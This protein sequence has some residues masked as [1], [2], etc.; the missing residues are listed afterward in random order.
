MRT[1][2]AL[3]G[4]L[5]RVVF[6]PLWLLAWRAR[7]PR[8]AWIELRLAAELGEIAMPQPPWRAFLARWQPRRLRSIAELRRLGV[9]LGTDPRMEGLVVHI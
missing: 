2:I 7:R 9:A 4:N 6:F 3:V 8:S 1:A 5:L